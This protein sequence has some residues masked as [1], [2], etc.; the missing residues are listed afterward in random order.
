[1]SLL[2][3]WPQK[4]KIIE[5]TTAVAIV[6]LWGSKSARK[7]VMIHSGDQQISRNEKSWHYYFSLRLIWNVLSVCVIAKPW[8]LRVE[9]I[10]VRA[11]FVL[12]CTEVTDQLP[13]PTAL[14]WMKVNVY[15]GQEVWGSEWV[16]SS[17]KCKSMLLHKMSPTKQ[18]FV[19]T[20]WYKILQG[21]EKTWR[22]LK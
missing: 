20:H 14:L 1:M 6:P 19:L 18:Q 15:Y 13:V 17:Y 9:E 22:I 21:T 2:S 10:N 5:W 7:P 3:Q 4:K 11:A 8:W 16:S 12:N